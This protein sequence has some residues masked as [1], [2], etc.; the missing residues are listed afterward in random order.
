[1]RLFKLLVIFTMLTS[2]MSFDQCSD[3]YGYDE[4]PELLERA[5]LILILPK[6]YNMVPIIKNKQVRYDLA[7]RLENGIEIRYSI[8][9]YDSLL[10]E[11][12]AYLERKAKGIKP[13]DPVKGEFEELKV[14]PNEIYKNFFLSFIFNVSE[15]NDTSYEITFNKMVRQVMEFPT[16]AVK[17][18]FNA[19]YGAHTW[20][21]LNKEF[22]KE[23]K[24]CQIFMIHKKDCGM[25]ICFRLFKDKNHV[26]RL[27]KD[28][29]NS[30]NFNNIQ[31]YR[32][33][34]P[35]LLHPKGI[36]RIFQYE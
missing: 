10:E 15:K 13:V 30:D 23:Y 29:I 21:K 31:F 3:N 36:N 11:Y 33:K 4:L 5:N 35:E 6:E 32:A 27:K 18:E 16:D 26:E 7:Y 9:P 1:M 12:N 25:V 19:D 17:E 8:W 20:C 24:E 2:L 28:K 14:N 34:P 22:G